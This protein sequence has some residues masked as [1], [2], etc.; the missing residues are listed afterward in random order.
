MEG[1]ITSDFPTLMAIKS[2]KAG[3][4]EGPETP[5]QLAE[6][7]KLLA[8][9]LYKNGTDVSLWFDHVAQAE[10]T[11]YGTWSKAASNSIYA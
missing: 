8:T 9:Q 3:K 4:Y 7:P 6:K 10:T 1:S 5:S 11:Y 2:L